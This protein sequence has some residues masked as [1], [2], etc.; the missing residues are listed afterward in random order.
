MVMSVELT[1]PRLTSF[2]LSGRHLANDI[3]EKRLTQILSCRPLLFAS[4]EPRGLH[5]RWYLC[6]TV[7]AVQQV[8][9]R[10]DIARWSGDV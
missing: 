3:T 1:C 8:R 5:V 2:G 9:C 10:M 6:H 4:S 7:G